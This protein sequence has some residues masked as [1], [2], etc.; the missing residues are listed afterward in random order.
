MYVYT[1]LVLVMQFEE[2]VHPK[3]NN[4]I[5]LFFIQINMLASQTFFKTL[6]Y[7]LARFQDINRCRYSLKSTKNS[8]SNI[9]FVYSC[10]FS[11]QFKSQVRLFCLRI[12]VN[13]FLFS[14]CL[15]KPPRFQSDI[16][17]ISFIYNQMYHPIDGI[18]ITCIF[19]IW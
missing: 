15:L 16:P 6:A 11:T 19:Q 14:S 8:L 4:K 10:I 1:V 9:C 7:F 2:D 18:I 12:A 13:A 17:L 3:C 5:V